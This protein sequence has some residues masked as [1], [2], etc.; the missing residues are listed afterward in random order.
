MAAAVSGEQAG[1]AGAPAAP[2]VP[3]RPV[4][5]RRSVLLTRLGA[6][7]VAILGWQ[8]ASVVIDNPSVF[9]SFP[10]TIEALVEL[11]KTGE[12]WSAVAETVRITAYGELLAILIGVP[13]GILIGVS[14]PADHFLSGYVNVFNAMP[15]AVA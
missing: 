10:E 7:A 4:D 11:S 15:R 9:P 3:R 1:A 13:I 12:F 8:L 14:R 2:F 5:R 6:V